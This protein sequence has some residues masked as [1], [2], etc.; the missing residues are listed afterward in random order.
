MRDEKRRAVIQ[1]KL[2]SVI[3]SLG[4]VAA[5]D[6]AARCIVDLVCSDAL[7]AE[8][9]AIF[10]PA[11]VRSVQSVRP[12]NE[13]CASLPIRYAARLLQGPP[14]G[15]KPNVHAAFGV[16]AVWNRARVQIAPPICVHV[17]STSVPVTL[18]HGIFDGTD[19]GGA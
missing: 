2:D 5:S 7:Q 14:R 15:L 6:R 11:R 1:A 18:N 19:T 17:C 4:E 10:S 12:R 8:S 9:S 13:L 16:H 3:G